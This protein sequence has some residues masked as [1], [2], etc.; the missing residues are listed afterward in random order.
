[1]KTKQKTAPPRPPTEPATPKPKPPPP[2]RA[3]TNGS[4]NS[5]DRLDE[6]QLLGALTA[7]KRGDFSVRLPDDWTGLGGKI[8]DTFNEVIGM[9]QR[10]AREA[11]PVARVVRHGG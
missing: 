5:G 8:A 3:A 1:M 6:K 9:N 2:T 11:D 7:F 10:L 4:R